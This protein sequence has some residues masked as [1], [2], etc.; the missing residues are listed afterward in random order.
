ME[1]L[2]KGWIELTNR[3]P[4]VDSENRKKLYINASSIVSVLDKVYSDERY[5]V[6]NTADGRQATVYETP[7]WVLNEIS[8]V[9]AKHE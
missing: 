4:L 3:N 5:T 6:V 7:A 2:P 9:E 8:K 1:K